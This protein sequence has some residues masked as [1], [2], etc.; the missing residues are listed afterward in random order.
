MHT[1]S[2]TYMLKHAHIYMH[3]HMHIHI[4]KTVNSHQ[5]T[6][7]PNH[8][9]RVLSCLPHF[10]FYVPFSWLRNLAPKF[11]HLLLIYLKLFKIALFIHYK[12]QL[13]L[14]HTSECSLRRWWRDRWE[15]SPLP[16]GASE[17]PGWSEEQREQPKVFQHIWRSKTK[18]CRGH[19][20]M[21]Q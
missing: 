20:K 21:R 19:W 4:F 14:Q 18:N 15:Q 13:L 11:I 17:M 5:Y 7:F 16:L 3:M 9:Y 12:K 10:M 6:Q 8:H 1:Y 2:Y